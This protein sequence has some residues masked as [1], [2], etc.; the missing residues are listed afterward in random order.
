MTVISDLCCH[1]LFWKELN[2][3]CLHAHSVVLL[4][5]VLPWSRV[6]FVPGCH[7]AE[8]QALFQGSKQITNQFLVQSLVCRWKISILW[9]SAG[10]F[11]TYWG[12]GFAYQSTFRRSYGSIFTANVCIF[13]CCW[14]RLY[15]SWFSVANGE[16]KSA[17][18][19]NK[20]DKQNKHTRSCG[21]RVYIYQ[22]WTLE[23]PSPQKWTAAPDYKYLASSLP[24]FLPRSSWIYSDMDV[25]ACY[26]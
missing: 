7:P 24:T 22:L 1:L 19:Q 9:A 10:R 14:M 16:A 13:H 4:A 12:A 17:A 5:R 21:V 18:S 8:N 6:E 11:S 20:N 3:W 2:R 26:L 25:Y 23:I 15:E